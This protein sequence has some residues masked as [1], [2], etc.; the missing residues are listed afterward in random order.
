MPLFDGYRDGDFFRKLNM[1]LINKVVDTEVA[2]FQINPEQTTVNG[3]GE[4]TNRVYYSPIKIHCLID[5]NDPSFDVAGGTG[6]DYKQSITFSF[7]YDELEN[8]NY[9]PTMGDIV[10]WDND[11]YE[12]GE[13]FQNEY[14]SGKNPKTHFGE[15]DTGYNV[16]IKCKGY[17]TKVNQLQIIERP[18]R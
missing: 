11:F 6:V 2:L 1:E 14:F 12:L 4:A 5:R 7:L 15:D 16:S 17:I 10:E 13:I 18:L 8:K 3:Y 9:S